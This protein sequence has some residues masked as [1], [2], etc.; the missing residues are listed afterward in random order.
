MS[1]N[2][3]PVASDRSARVLHAALT[4]VLLLG[5]AALAGIRQSTGAAPLKVGSLLEFVIAAVAVAA[6]GLSLLVR[7][8]FEGR[9]ADETARLW[10]GESGRVPRAV[11]IWA[12][13]QAGGLI[14][15]TLYFLTGN[16]PI[17]GGLVVVAFLSLFFFSPGRLAGD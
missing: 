15:A 11:V 8:G 17:A 16:W 6:L 9:E 4:G 13:A 5:S 3:Q 12:L 10:W 7:L 14:G 1:A 2:P